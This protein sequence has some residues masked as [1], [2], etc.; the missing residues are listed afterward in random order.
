MADAKKLPFPKGLRVVLFGMPAAGKSSLLGALAQAGQ[1]QAGALGAT[2]EDVGGGLED[3]RLRL[4]QNR[5]QETLE[6]IVPYPVVLKPQGGDSP[7]QATLFDC[8]GRVALEFLA[9][10]RSLDAAADQA[11]LAGAVHRADAL[12]LVVDASAEGSQL[13]QDFQ[14]F[15]QFLRTLERSRGKRIEIAGLPV[16]LVLSKCDLLAQPKDTHIRWVERIEQAKRVLDQKFRDFLAGQEE[17]DHIPF[18]RIDLHVWA[19]A[20]K[21]P[22]L[23]D[24]PARPT[25]PY[26]VAELFRQAVAGATAYR[27]RRSGAHLR[28]LVTVVSLLGVLG[29]LAA[30]VAWFFANRPSPELIDLRNQARS[31]LPAR[32]LSA[33]DRLRGPLEEKLRKLK[34]VQDDPA[35]PKLEDDLRNDIERAAREIATYQDLEA[36]FRK[37]DRLLGELSRE[38]ELKNLE[39]ALDSLKVPDDFAPAWTGTPLVQALQRRRQ[40]IELVRKTMKEEID[41]IDRQVQAGLALEKEGRKLAEASTAGQRAAWSQKVLDYRKQDLRHPPDHN[42]S[43]LPSVQYRLI[44]RMESVDDGRREWE[45]VKGKLEKLRLYVL[46]L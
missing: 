1:V 7:V 16:W 36:R 29:G 45:T 15:A 46:S 40:E 32:D 28:L 17:R 31:A 14:Q 37:A 4:Y 24:K 5:S 19:T 9:R 42:L 25:E 13:R 6:E 10:K 44:Y 27:G 34:A 12:I 33:Q 8:D 26:G 23:A 39:T 22:T 20:V 43:E 18:G 21:R 41:W 3:L 38:E 2:L 11:Q 30:L 35:Y